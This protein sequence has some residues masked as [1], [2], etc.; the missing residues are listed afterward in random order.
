VVTALTWVLCWVS[1][2]LSGVSLGAV[3]SQSWR[4][5]RVERMHD[6]T[7]APCPAPG[8]TVGRFRK[9]WDARVRKL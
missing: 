2:M 5:R 9:T 8:C 3:C 6:H 1:V 4:R 7:G